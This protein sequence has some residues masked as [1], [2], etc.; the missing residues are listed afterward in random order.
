VPDEIAVRSGFEASVAGKTAECDGGDAVPGT[1]LG[2]RQEFAGTLTGDYVDHG[3]PPWR[4]YRMNRLT[5]KPERYAFDEVWCESDS[6]Y[7]DDPQGAAP[8]AP[9]TGPGATI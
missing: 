7:L 8:P 3:E 9:H 2:G 5:R 4:W 1:N 6:L